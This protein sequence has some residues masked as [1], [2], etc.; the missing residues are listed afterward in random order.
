MFPNA[1]AAP[2]PFSQ[3][4]RLIRFLRS[5]K[6]TD[7]PGKRSVARTDFAPQPT[8]RSDFYSACKGD[9]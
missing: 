9:F 3:S 2:H 8:I 1:S 6:C 4:F 5:G 7:I